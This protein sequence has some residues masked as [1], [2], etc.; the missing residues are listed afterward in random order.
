[1]SVSGLSF[2]NQNRNWQIE[3]QRWNDQ[4]STTSL[5]SSVLTGALTNQSAG[6]AAISNHQALLRI[7]KQLKAAATS[8]VNG[9]SPAQRAQLSSTSSSPTSTKTSSSSAA[10]S[11]DRLA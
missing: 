10:H 3:Q 7:T 5:L 2:Y 8:V 11:L 1:V 9:L 4:F 6:L